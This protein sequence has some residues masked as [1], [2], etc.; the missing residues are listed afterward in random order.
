MTTVLI[1]VLTHPIFAQEP[2]VTFIEYTEGGTSIELPKIQFQHDV[3]INSYIDVRFHPNTL[4]L[5][6]SNILSSPE[7]IRLRQELDDLNKL[8]TKARDELNEYVRSI[9]SLRVQLL[10]GA[11]A[12]VEARFRKKLKGHGLLIEKLLDVLEPIEEGRLLE[13][14]LS[15]SDPAY[16]DVLSLLAEH[17][18]NVQQELHAETSLLIQNNELTFNVWCIHTSGGKEPTA[19]HLNNY[20]NLR[21]GSFHIVDKDTFARTEDE[22]RHLKESVR[23]HE[24]LRKLIKDIG[25][26]QSEIRQVFREL[27]D[28]F[29]SDLKGFENLFGTQELQ[30]L[31]DEIDVEIN[32][33]PASTKIEALRTDLTK[34]RTELKEF[35]NLKEQNASLVEELSRRRDPN[36]LVLFELLSERMNRFEELKNKLSEIAKLDRINKIRQL[37]EDLE[38]TLEEM[39][40]SILPRLRKTINELVKEKS[41]IWI[42]SFSNLKEIL[43]KY[44]SFSDYKDDFR[45][46]AE[47]KSFV[48]TI[49]DEVPDPGD[50]M[51]EEIREV[52]FSEAPPTVINIPRT[53][54]QENDIYN[55]YAQIY[56]EGSPTLRREYSFRIKKYGMYSKWTGNLIF[57]KGEW[58]KSFQPA[59]SVSWILHYRSRPKQR[60]GKIEGGGG[61]LGNVLNLGF[62]L[63]SVVF[64]TGSSIEYGLGFTITF[65][66]DIL[67]IGYGINFQKENRRGYFFIGASLFDLLNQTRS[68]L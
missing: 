49:S 58:Q 31:L 53:N 40:T 20:D 5:D 36:P 63:N 61:I 9:G 42:A 66:S 3:D 25:N 6:D 13:Q 2:F 55:L 28:Q 64:S 14:A 33:S 35:F 60:N 34:L 51:P 46:L 41:Q 18:K 56:R 50:L 47:R 27:R 15:T 57:A 62:G 8:L 68:E 10:K 19:I 21:A 67:Q 59:T 17:I 12:E 43:K 24:D 37:V 45:G 26:K 30:S 1:T 32:K 29:F 54:R 4:A 39:P 16:A 38:A 65:L 22:D 23:F 44:E 52:A 11:D 7:S 48:T